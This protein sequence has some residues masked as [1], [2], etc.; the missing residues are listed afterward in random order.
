MPLAAF[1]ATLRPQLTATKT[2]RPLAPG[3]QPGVIHTYSTGHPDEIWLK[4][5]EVKHGIER[6]TAE[7]W[8]GLIEYYRK[9]PAHAADPNFEAGT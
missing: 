2:V 6:H 5:L 3:A 1:G 8:H 9:Q 7:Q 4:L